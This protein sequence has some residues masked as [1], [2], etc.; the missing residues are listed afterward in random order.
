[1]NITYQDVTSNTYKAYLKMKSNIK[2]IVNV[3]AASFREV[4]VRVIQQWYSRSDK[5]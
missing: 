1:M 5:Q 3:T 2:L 4:Y